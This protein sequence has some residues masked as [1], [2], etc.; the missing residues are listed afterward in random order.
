MLP[1]IVWLFVVRRVFNIYIYTQMIL[2]IVWLFVVLHVFNI[3]I[4][5]HRCFL[6]FSCCAA[7]IQHIHIYTQMIPGIVWLFV[8]L[9]VFST[10]IHTDDSWYCLAVCCTACIQY[11]HIYTQMIPGIAWLWCWVFSLATIYLWNHQLLIVRC[12]A[13]PVENGSGI[14]HLDHVDNLRDPSTVSWWG[15]WTK[16]LTPSL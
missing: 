13:L 11:L 7:C 5:A 3:Y 8:V 1:G 12:Q 10:Y 14:D 9:R 16:P 4:Y 15:P 6:V 2:G